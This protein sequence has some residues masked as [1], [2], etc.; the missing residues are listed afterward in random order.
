MSTYDQKREYFGGQ[1]GDVWTYD[2][3]QNKWG[4][5]PGGGGGGGEGDITGV[6]AQSP[7]TGGGTSGG[8]TIGL[9]TVP[10]NKGGTGATDA[11][12]AR[13][14]LGAAAATHTHAAG[15]VTSGTFDPARLGT[16]T[17]DGTKF[18]RDDGSWQPVS[19]GGSA[20]SDEVAGL[21]MPI[22]AFH[23]TARYNV[24]D[25]GGGAVSAWGD[26]SGSGRDVAQATAG[27]RPTLGTDGSSEPCLLFGG[28]DLLY[29]TTNLPNGTLGD[30]WA[31]LRI[32]DDAS[33]AGGGTMVIVGSNDLASFTRFLHLGIITDSGVNYV[34]TQQ[35][36]ND[37]RCRVVGDTPIVVGQWHVV[38]WISDGAAWRIQ[39][40]G[41]EQSLTVEL[42]SNDGDWFGDTS[43]RDYLAIGSAPTMAFPDGR[44]TL[45]GAIA[46]VVG[47]DGVWL[48]DGK[49]AHVYARLAAIRD[50][51]NS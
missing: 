27:F 6:T 11:A 44:S 2:A 31:V 49:A 35:Q 34:F 7:L 26:E 14:N 47:W 18:L 25:A 5:A 48:R 29:R 17:R 39:V 36:N 9:S 42:G 20:A 24:T 1:D 30:V 33:T 15:D 43:A 41:V 45:K 32:D 21:Y 28:D 46:E 50:R 8:V 22:P 4:P 10:V 23:Y 51:L 13:T 19:G 37:T 38:R 16:G 12:T 40:D 3:A